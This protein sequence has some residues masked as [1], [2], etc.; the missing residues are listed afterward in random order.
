MEKQV[1]AH[2]AHLHEATWRLDDNQ[3]KSA[4]KVLKRI[5]NLDIE[6]ID[7]PTEDGISS[8]AFN[9]KDILEDYGDEII[10]IA[11]DSTCKNLIE[12][13]FNSTLIYL[14]G[15]QTHWD[16]N[17]MQLLEKRMAKHFL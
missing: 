4:M 6:I 7:L 11:M 2:W 15:K 16:M 17:F 1:Y 5:D 10:E 3:V 9:F 12:L 8:L 13:N 14:K